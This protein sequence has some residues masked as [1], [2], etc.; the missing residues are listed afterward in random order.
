MRVDVNGA[1]LCVDTFGDSADPAVLVKERGLTQVSDAGALDAIVEGV[2]ADPKSQK[3]VADFRA[4]QGERGGDQRQSGCHD[5][6]SHALWSSAAEPLFL[7]TG[8]RPRFA[9][10]G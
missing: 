5:R 3:A 4:G 9:G 10:N 6:D 8:H 2:L 1:Q 7:F